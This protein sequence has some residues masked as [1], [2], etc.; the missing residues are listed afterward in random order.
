[1]EGY[2]WVGSRFSNSEA[3]GIE[4]V[5]VALKRTATY[6]SQT[7]EFAV[8]GSCIWLRARLLAFWAC[9]RSVSG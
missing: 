8:F 3:A 2:V 1:M 9:L 5:V 7:T 4:S 6:G